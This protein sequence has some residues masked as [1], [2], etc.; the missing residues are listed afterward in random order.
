MSEEHGATQH[1]EIHLPPPSFAP[2]IVAAGAALTLTGL[3][4]PVLLA[5]GVVLLL[6]GIGIWAF[7]Y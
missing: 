2:I 1:E 6:A 7:G 4:S 5:L 3:L